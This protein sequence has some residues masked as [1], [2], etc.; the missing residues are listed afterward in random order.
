MTKKKVLHNVLSVISWLTLANLS[1][2]FLLGELDTFHTVCLMIVYSILL[3][4]LI[5]VIASK[6][7]SK[8]VYR[9]E[10]KALKKE[11]NYL[12]EVHQ[13]RYK[14]YFSNDRKKIEMYSEGIQRYGEAL[15][16]IGEYYLSKD[17]FNE[18]QRSEIEEIVDKIKELMQKE[19]VT[20]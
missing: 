17:G 13:E 14:L 5:I 12:K 6:I 2:R 3:L 4:C 1:I 7:T 16:S 10:C 11:Y 19:F 20:Y 18:K 15:L 8:M 9:K